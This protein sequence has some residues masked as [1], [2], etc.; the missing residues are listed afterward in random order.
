MRR[1]RITHTTGFN[2]DGEVSA[3]YNEARMLPLDTRKQLLMHS[4][5]DI[6]RVTSRDAYVDYWGTRVTRS[7]RF[8]RTVRS[9]SAR[10]VSSSCSP[11]NTYPEM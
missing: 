3:S 9:I 7:S 5:L 11:A 1:L 2:Y 6:T 10:A 4:T 8:A